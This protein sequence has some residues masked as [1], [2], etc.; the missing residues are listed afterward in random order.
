MSKVKTVH[1]FFDTTPERKKR[2]DEA[3]DTLKRAGGGSLRIF[4]EAAIDEKLARDEK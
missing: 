2:I 1:V 4:M 3:V